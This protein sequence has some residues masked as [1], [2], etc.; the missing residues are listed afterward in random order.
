LSCYT[1]VADIGFAPIPENARLKRRRAAALL[2][3]VLLCGCA[4]LSLPDQEMASGPIP[5]GKARIIIAAGRWYSSGVAQSYPNAFDV[6]ID[7]IG[8]GRVGR[9]EAMAVDVLPGRHVVT[10]HIAGLPDVLALDGD[11]GEL[12]AG[13][14]VFVTVDRVASGI[15]APSFAGDANGTVAPHLEPGEYLDI[16][17]S[18]V[19]LPPSRSFVAPDA[20]AVARLN[21]R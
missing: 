21:A 7:G 8:V 18:A 14:R 10:R 19:A 17:N 4:W 12:A 11:L 2:A 13:Q 15:N 3:C 9:D 1:I 5:A 6:A 20:E 16:G